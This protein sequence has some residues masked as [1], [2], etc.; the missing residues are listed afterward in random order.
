MIAIYNNRYSPRE[1]LPQERMQLYLDQARRL[2]QTIACFTIEDVD[3]E[4]ATIEA[5]VYEEDWISK[6]IPFPDLLF[7]ER[8]VVPKRATDFE[9]DLRLQKEIP[10]FF[11]LIDNKWVL[12]Q[13]LENTNAWNKLLIPTTRLDQYDQFLEHLKQ[14]KTVVLK[15]T[16]ASKGQG[17]YKV[18]K[19]A[20]SGYYV[21]IRDE[22]HTYSYMR[23]KS[24]IQPL[25][26]QGNYIVQPF[27][28]SQT[29]DGETF[30]LRAHLIRDA[31]GEWIVLAAI[32]DVAKKGRF[33]T[34]QSAYKNERAE[35]FLQQLD[36]AGD[37]LYQ[38]WLEQSILLARD[39][40]SLYP[41]TLPELALDFALDD[42]RTLRFFEA[43]T[44]PEVFAFKEE[45]EE[46]RAQELI[47]FA[48]HVATAIAP[49]PKEQRYGRYFKVGQ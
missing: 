23:L 11:H 38:E 16:D 18:T 24:F 7:N 39:I 19:A 49:I 9:K 32:A 36:P 29:P 25:I 21:T 26:D 12:Q 14:Q 31:S 5:E 13:K 22:R 15:P 34:N 33:I 40:D 6:T 20:G 28:K 3:F 27:I 44:G 35:H 2:G 17:I 30:H 46:R 4:T 42:T 47:T 43:N 41:F 37:V 48:H 1:V 8:C 10:C 45:R